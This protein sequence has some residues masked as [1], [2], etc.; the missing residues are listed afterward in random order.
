MKIGILGA[1]N[2]EIAPIL[3]SL[4]E[5]TGEEYASNTF[6]Q[7]TLNDHNLT[8]AC[9]KIGKVASALSAALLIERYGCEIVL[10]SGVAGSLNKNLHIGDMLIATSCVQHDLDITAFGHPA[11]FVPGINIAPKSDESLNQIA[12]QVASQ[13][14]IKLFEGIVASGDQFVCNVNK[15]V[16]IKDAFNADAVEMEGASVAQV[17]DLMKVPFFVLRAISDEAGSGA[18]FG[19]DEFLKDSA[20]K[21]AKFLLEMIKKI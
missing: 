21:S 15:K 6:Y 11:G 16:W 1:M 2:E 8:I 18:E 5:Y 14:N 17:C 12:R 3:A 20:S 7:A 13:L 19:F 9:T 10:F 4:K